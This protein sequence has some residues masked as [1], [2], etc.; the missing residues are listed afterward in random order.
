MTPADGLLIAAVGVS[1]GATCLALATARLRDA[2]ALQRKAN[3][4]RRWANQEL[5]EA[6]ART[7]R[8][9]TELHIAQRRFEDAARMAHPTYCPY[10]DDWNR[11]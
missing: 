1:I 6:V 10:P 7:D 8:A 4:Y 3:R 11:P 9:A 5:A 2:R